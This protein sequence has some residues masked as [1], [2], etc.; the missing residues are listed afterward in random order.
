MK[1]Y[2]LMLGL[3][4]LMGFTQSPGNKTRIFIAGDSTA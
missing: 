3:A 4:L 1:R 2:M